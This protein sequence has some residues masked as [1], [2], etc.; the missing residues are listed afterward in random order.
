METAQVS[1][2]EYGESYCSDDDSPYGVLASPILPFDAA[3][4]FTDVV[5]SPIND[6]HD[7]LG[8]RNVFS[9]LH[10]NG[11]ITHATDC[12]SQ[13]TV[14]SPIHY[15]AQTFDRPVVPSRS[16]TL[17]QAV[18]LNAPRLPSFP[19]RS[20]SLAETKRSASTSTSLSEATGSSSGYSASPAP[21]SKPSTPLSTISTS[22][23]SSN[24][25]AKPRGRPRKRQNTDVSKATSPPRVVDYP[26]PKFDGS[27]QN[28]T[29]G[30]PTPSFDAK[31]I[32]PKPSEPAHPPPVLSMDE[33]PIPDAESKPGQA[34]FK[35]N[36][37]PEVKEK[38]KKKPILACLF[39]RERKIACGQPLPGSTK[40]K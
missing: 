27:N 2:A 33:I 3:S 18:T 30:L 11:L 39:C 6:F 12:S 16:Y 25:S 21:S 40:C 1:C 20:P 24:G 34:I 5:D 36:S 17:D 13:D 32:A 37:P 7:G 38:P 28:I 8:V 10:L 4:P 23:S 35:L 19:P 26:F 22:T 31:R 29:S 14:H 9:A 15:N